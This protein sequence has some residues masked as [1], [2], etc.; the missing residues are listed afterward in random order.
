MYSMFGFVPN[1]SNIAFVIQHI[2]KKAVDKTFFAKYLW[3]HMAM[4]TL[5]IYEGSTRL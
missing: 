1:A 2:R 4:E 3:Q 5:Q